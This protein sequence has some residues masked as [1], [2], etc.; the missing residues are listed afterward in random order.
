MKV[1][2]GQGKSRVKCRI[3][4][5][6]RVLFGSELASGSLSRSGWFQNRII[7]KVLGTVRVKLTPQT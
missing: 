2:E 3:R 5:S 1:R 4:V 6:V 7:I